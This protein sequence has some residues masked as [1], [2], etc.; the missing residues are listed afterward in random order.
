MDKYNS[1]R[2]YE[3][4]K[5]PEC[6]QAEE[7]RRIYAQAQVKEK[8]S[9]LKDDEFYEI[10]YDA[11]PLPGVGKFVLK[12]QKV[13]Q[14]ERDEVRELF[15]QM[16]DIARVNRTFVSSSN[17]F[18]D[19][20]VQKEN[21]WIFYKQGIFMKDFEDEYDRTVTYSSYFPNYQMMGYEQL[22]TYF[23]WRTQ[24][25]QGNVAETSLS[26]AFL[27]TYEL[28]NNIGVDSPQDGLERLVAFRNAFRSYDQTID[29]Y[30]IKWLKDYHIYYELPWS[31]REFAEKNELSMYYPELDE[32]DN[33]FTLYSR[34]SKYNICKSAFY[35]E[36]RNALIQDC[37]EYTMDRLSRI[38]EENGL[39]L[40]EAVFQ[41]T[42]N[43]ASWE[44]FKGA[45]FYHWKRQP[46]RKVVISRK[47]I[48]LCS[49]NSW[50]YSSSVTTESG[51]KLIGYVMKQME[52]VL[53]Q[54]TKYK[55]K[56]SADSDLVVHEA[57]KVL[58][59][60]G[61]SLE[62]VVTG[63]V[64]DFYREATKT[65]VKVD[66]GV[67]SRIRQEAWITQEKLTVPE[68]ENT[69]LLIMINAQAQAEKTHQ[70]AVNDT[71]TRQLTFEDMVSEQWKHEGDE[72]SGSRS[73]LRSVFEEDEAPDSWSEL[74]NA[75]TE[76]ELEALDFILQK[77]CDL[78]GE[79]D[80][81]EFA[82]HH[83]VMLEV[84]IDG[85]N[86]K[87]MDYIGDSLVDEEFTV[88]EDYAEEVRKMMEGT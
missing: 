85:I 28:L 8:V 45:L 69:G 21:S 40:E 88:Y 27:Y 76:M 80:I 36:D 65:V 67:L 60:K 71:E 30:M 62:A 86:E 78:Y 19:K 33:Y 25:R 66:P 82:D 5:I 26:Y 72:V 12:S 18:Y 61:I 81:K 49:S 37:F 29:K 1:E 56:L 11:C 83:G 9:S 74:K 24:V 54:L 20:R 53:R 77:D 58:R 79:A 87:A 23:T 64:K 6:S 70:H 2:N 57:V 32:S 17:R 55:Y 44:P 50:T 4:F 35:T 68:E 59:E 10:E 42:K 16:R 13:E 47:E 15:Y 39:S 22:R 41:A 43:M 51:K 73:K 63:A 48:Y 14:P 46:D 34:I 75:L 3:A 84:L 52:A 7:N 31:F 38:F